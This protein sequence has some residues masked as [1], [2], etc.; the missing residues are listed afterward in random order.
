MNAVVGAANTL[1]VEFKL[2]SENQSLSQETRNQYKQLQTQASEIC[3]ALMGI[4][5]G[6]S[7]ALKTN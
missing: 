2:A 7:A 4:L 5:V 1:F 3:I 6:T